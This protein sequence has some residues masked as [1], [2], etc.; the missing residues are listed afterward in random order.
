MVRK[1]RKPVGFKYCSVLL[2][3]TGENW[4]LMRQFN[5]YNS[6][7]EAMNCAATIAPA[8]P[9]TPHPK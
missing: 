6:P 3:A 1:M 4:S 5:A 9:R 2:I 7:A 8:A